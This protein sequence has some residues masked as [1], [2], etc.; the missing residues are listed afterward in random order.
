MAQGFETQV[1]EKGCSLVGE[2]LFGT[3]KVSAST[4]SIFSE[5]A[6]K[7]KVRWKT[8]PELLPVW[9]GN[10]DPDRLMLIAALYIQKGGTLT[11]W[12]SLG[13]AY[14]IPQGNVQ[15]VPADL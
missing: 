9:A 12:D 5:K 4:S 2:H 10:T 1:R 7:Y 15:H 8:L 11:Q 6:L 13:L 14:W 3:E